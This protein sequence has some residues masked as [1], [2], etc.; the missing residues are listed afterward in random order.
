MLEFLLLFLL[1]S[2]PSIPMPPYRRVETLKISDDEYN[3]RFAVVG[4]H[5]F[6]ASHGYC[7]AVDLKR[8]KRRWKVRLSEFR[9]PR[10]FTVR[11]ES[12]LGASTR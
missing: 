3:D 12:R 5:L 8:I 10:D 7:V 9:W 11:A 2:E 4:N 6:T 1:G